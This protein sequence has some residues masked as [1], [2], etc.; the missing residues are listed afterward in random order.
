[1][2][3]MAWDALFRHPIVGSL[4]AA[5]GGFPV[6]PLGKDLGGFR[7]CLKLLKEGERVCIFP[8]GERSIDGHLMPLRKGIARLA[9]LMGLPITPVRITGANLAWMRGDCGPRPWFKI[10]VHYCEPIHPRPTATASERRAE[11]E[12]IMNELQLA[13]DPTLQAD[14]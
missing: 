3:F 4:V 7:T 8:E 11:S 2:R 10:G 14:G 6:D 1:M 9:L 12:R 13:I 5:G